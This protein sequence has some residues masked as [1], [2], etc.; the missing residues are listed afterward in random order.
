[1]L[2]VTTLPEACRAASG[3]DPV[4]QAGICWAGV[5]SQCTLAAEW[6]EHHGLCGP[7]Y[8]ELFGEPTMV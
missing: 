1:M 8:A 5:R 4:Y 2:M 7:H 3:G 6:N